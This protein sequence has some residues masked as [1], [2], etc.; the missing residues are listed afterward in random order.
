MSFALKSKLVLKYFKTKLVLINT[1][2]GHARKWAV[3][4]LATHTSTQHTM[5]GVNS[6]VLLTED[7]IF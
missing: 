5:L 1:R 6:V 2:A 7:S 4:K 3:A